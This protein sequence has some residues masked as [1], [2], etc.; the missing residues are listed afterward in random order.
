MRLIGARSLNRPCG[1]LRKLATGSQVD[2]AAIS[3]HVSFMA[4]AKFRP[5]N[6]IGLGVAVR[7]HLGQ[8]LR[9]VY[10]DLIAS[11]LPPDLVRLIGYLESSI[12]IP[13][14]PRDP[15]RTAKPAV[16]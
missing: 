4:G 11:D 12:R 10:S 14:G 16:W 6:P 13:K 8:Q 9:G 15:A 2:A 1:R 7:E 3:Q 5:P